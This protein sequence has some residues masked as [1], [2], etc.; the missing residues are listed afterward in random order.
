M[1]FVPPPAYYVGLI[2]FIYPKVNN[3]IM[4]ISFDFQEQPPSYQQTMNK[5][6][7]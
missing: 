3:F 5:K 6:E 7:Q 2:L 4:I 1:A